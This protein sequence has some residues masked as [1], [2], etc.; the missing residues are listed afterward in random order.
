MGPALVKEVRPTRLAAAR[1]ATPYAIAL[2]FALWGLRGLESGTPVDTDA[3][4]HAMNGVFIRDVLVQGHPMH[5]VAFAKAYYSRYP[6]LSIPYHPPLFPLFEALFFFAFGVNLLAARLAVAAATA[7]GVVLLYRLVLRTHGSPAIAAAST[8]TFFSL[9]SAFTLASDVMLEMPT[10]ALILLSMT[11]LPGLDGNYSLRRYLTFAC[12]AAAAFWTKQNA[13]F[14]GMV[15]FAYAVLAGRWRELK[16]PALWISAALFGA[17][18]VALTL[19]SAAFGV[20]GNKDWPKFRLFAILGHNIPYYIEVLRLEFG[21]VPMLLIFIAVVAAVR[22]RQANVPYVA[23]AACV[24][25]LALVLPPYDLRYVFLGYPALIVVVCSVLYQASKRLISERFAWVPLAA[26]AALSVVA[27]LGTKPPFVRGPFEAASLLAPARPGRIL[28]CGRSNG[29]FIFAARS[30]DPQQKTTIVR[31]DKLPRAV[32]APSAFEQFAHDYGIDFVVLENSIIARPWDPL[33][34][35]APRSF[36]L[37]RDVPL[38]SSDAKM[39]GN[40]RILR[41]ANPSSTP[42][43]TLH[44]RTLGETVDTELPN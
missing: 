8:V 9:A 12:V 37:V 26:L 1:T 44:L 15:P 6:S 18:V 2:V 41:F 36:T 21:V 19:L 43:S 20:G 4:R 35:Q 14:L 7:L 27:H 22:H 32:F 42:E 40:L 10:L 31:G 5:L 11:Y 38:A 33:F 23:W 3:A 28:Y 34:Q 13:L 39:N 24:F 29:N 16:R 30:L 17:S 25:V